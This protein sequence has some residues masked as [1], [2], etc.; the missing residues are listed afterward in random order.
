MLL[1]ELIEINVY[2]IKS[3]KGIGLSNAWVDDLGL[4]FDRRFVLT[5]SNGQFITARTHPTICL[6][7]ASITPY[8]LLLTAPDMPVLNISYAKFTHEYR[9]VTVW[10][11]TIAGQYCAPEYDTWFSQ[12]LGKPCQL[13]FFGEQSS[14]RVKNRMNQVAFADGY[15]LLLI[16]EASLADLNGR[17]SNHQVSMAQFRPNIV[18]NNTEPFEEDT[19]KHIRIGEVEFEVVKPCSRCI[20][21]TIDPSNAEKHAKQEPLA[22]LKKYRQVESGDVMFG[23]NLVALNQGQIHLGDSVTVLSTQSPPAFHHVR[24]NRPKKA[25]ATTNTHTITSSSFPVECIKI[26]EE[27]HD[28]K[29]FWLKTANNAPVNYTAGQHLPLTFQVDGKEVNRCYTL[30]SSPTRPNLLSITVKRVSDNQVPGLVSN[31]LH[32]HLKVGD[33]LQAKQPSGQFHLQAINPEKILMLSAGSGIT[34]MLS[35]LRALVDQG[36][37]NDVAFFHSAH[38]EHDLIAIDEV[39]ALAKQHGN[40]RLEFTLTRSAPPEWTDY[41]GRLTEKMLSNIPQ[42][43]SR[44]VLVCGPEAFREHAKSLLMT[45]GL[46]ESQFHFESFGKRLTPQSKQAPAEEV[47]QVGILFDSWDTF[48]KG[49]TQEPLLD[50]A[51]TAG[52]AIP[53]SCRAGMCGT[54]KVKLESGDVEQ[55]AKDGLTD[56]EQEQ[57]Y[58]LS[59]SCIPKSDLVISGG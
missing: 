4:A 33:K 59:C 53:Y 5:D 48:H 2:P 51:E 52:L 20:F 27:T 47:K 19:W 42:L 25:I 15:P 16:S 40:C 9:Q 13:V 17:M 50:Q 18:I 39:K 10:K 44:E 49:N 41:Q 43:L 58:I 36:V 12:Y 34:P 57:G 35:M 56:L 55:L 37:E 30:S 54:C 1:S 26:T 45:L 29:T 3:S 21:T 46:P 38:S 28:V 6:I 7:S 24:G 11:D 31:F 14:R 8:G 32:D 22:T 23:Q